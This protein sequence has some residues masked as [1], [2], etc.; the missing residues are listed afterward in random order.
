MQ[1]VTFHFLGM[2][3]ENDKSYLSGRFCYRQF[4]PLTSVRVHYFKSQEVSY[5]GFIIG[6][7]MFDNLYCENCKKERLIIKL[8]T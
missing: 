7:L 1:E 6:A 4:I 5:S 3:N 8:G 2:T